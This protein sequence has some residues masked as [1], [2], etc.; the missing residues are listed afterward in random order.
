MVWPYPNPYRKKPYFRI[1]ENRIWY[2]FGT[3]IRGAFPYKMRIISDSKAESTLHPRYLRNTKK[4]ARI[5]QA[6][7]TI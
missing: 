4:T 6:K 2:G 5:R 1:G 3:G 7:A